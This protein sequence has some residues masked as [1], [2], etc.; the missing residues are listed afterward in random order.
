MGATP[1]LKKLAF[2]HTQTQFKRPFR[3][4]KQD[5]KSIKKHSKGYKIPR[6]RC[7]HFRWL[8]GCSQGS[9]FEPNLV[10]KSPFGRLLTGPWVLS[11]RSWGALGV[12]LAVLGVLLLPWGAPGTLLS[13]P[14]EAPG[15]LLGAFGPHLGPPRAI[16]KP[17]LDRSA[18]DFPRKSA[19][20]KAKNSKKK[21][22]S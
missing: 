11:G 4:N 6:F 21:K 18:H 2:E 9:L 10:P 22:Q 12:L 1:T 8:S 15:A 19:K 13:A 17:I 5:K 3:Q 16:Q 14:L 7:F 20:K